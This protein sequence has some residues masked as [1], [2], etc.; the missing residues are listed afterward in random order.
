VNPLISVLGPFIILL[1]LF[2]IPISLFTIIYYLS[3]IKT[4]EVGIRTSFQIRKDIL[5]KKL[6]NYHIKSEQYKLLSRKLLW[7]KDYYNE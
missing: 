1:I 6:K 5:I 7:F 3:N 2:F 4:K